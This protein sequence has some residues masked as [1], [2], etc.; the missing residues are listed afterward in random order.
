MG[1]ESAVHY[2]S[3]SDVAA[4]CETAVVDGRGQDGS[5][6]IALDRGGVDRRVASA[7]ASGDGTIR[8]R[9]EG[10]APGKEAAELRVAQFLVS[11]L[12]GLG[13]NWNV[14]G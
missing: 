8:D 12:S 1:L 13:G 11:W 9:I 10:G 14:P 2:V 7:D 3:G 5:E 6:R 4:V